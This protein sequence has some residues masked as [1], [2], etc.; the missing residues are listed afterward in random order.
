MYIIVTGYRYTYLLS[1]IA[2][3]SIGNRADSTEAERAG[4]SVGGDS[5]GARISDVI[6]TKRSRGTEATAHQGTCHFRYVHNVTIT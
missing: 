6:S 3:L 4:D 2:T 1:Y 5:A